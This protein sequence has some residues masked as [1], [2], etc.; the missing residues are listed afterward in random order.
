METLN[1]LAIFEDCLNTWFCN[2]T[3]L[4]LGKCGI[5]KGKP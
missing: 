4:D 3:T 5:F 2:D 1:D